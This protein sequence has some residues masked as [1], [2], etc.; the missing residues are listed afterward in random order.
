MRASGRVNRTCTL[1]ADSVLTAPQGISVPRTPWSKS[2]FL[3]LG[4]HPYI[5]TPKWRVR[6]GFLEWK[7][8]AALSHWL[9]KAA[10]PPAQATRLLSL[11]L[12][13]QRS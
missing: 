1:P 13:V 9:A 7:V 5:Y 10:F 6:V 12:W 4:S 8:Q 3:Q 2:L 11:L